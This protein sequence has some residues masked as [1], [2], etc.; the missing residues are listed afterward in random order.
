MQEFDNTKLIRGIDA[1][2]RKRGEL[3]NILVDVSRQGGRTVVRIPDVSYKLIAEVSVKPAY[4]GQIIPVPACMY[5]LLEP[6]EY[7]LFSRI[8]KE[9]T[10]HGECVKRRCELTKRGAPDNK[11]S[12]N[13]IG[14]LIDMG[15]VTCERADGGRYRWRIK[16]D[17]IEKFDSIVDGEGKLTIERLRKAAS[18]KGI[19]KITKD[20]LI[21]IYDEYSLRTNHDAEDEEV[22]D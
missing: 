3:E 19:G 22:Y 12:Y 4:T 18:K 9:I 16:F 7:Y 17:D 10:E 21:K 20:D 2:K 5:S 13:T 1:V 11:Y 14:S 8:L 15:I 6:V